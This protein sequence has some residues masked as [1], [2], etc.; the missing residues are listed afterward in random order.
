MNAGKGSTRASCVNSD[1][2]LQGMHLFEQFRLKHLTPKQIPRAVAI[3][4]M[5]DHPDLFPKHHIRNKLPGPGPKILPAFR[6][7]DTI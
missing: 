1:S 4:I 6:T 7:I 3:D 5:F 2:L